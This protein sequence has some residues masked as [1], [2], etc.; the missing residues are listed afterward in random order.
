MPVVV[1]ALIVL[2]ALLLFCALAPQAADAMFNGAQKWVVMQF[3][4]FYIV[5]V[6]AFLLFLVFLAVSRYGDIRLGPDDAKPEFSFVSWSAMLF[7]AGMGIGLMYFGV[8]EP[9]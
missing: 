1:P 2:G 9:L 8:G 7:A 4:W 6:T 3:D 5:A